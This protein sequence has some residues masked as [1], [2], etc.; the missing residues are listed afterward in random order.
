MSDAQHFSFLQAIL[1]FQVVSD[2]GRLNKLLLHQIKDLCG[3][4]ALF[5]S[6]TLFL[7]PFA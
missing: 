6:A 4:S 2:E 5:A 1:H 3:E 7:G